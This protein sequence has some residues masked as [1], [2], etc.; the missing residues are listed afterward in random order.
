ML[1]AI[2]FTVDL[3]TKPPVPGI[4][5][6]PARVLDSTLGHEA[7]D[8]AVKRQTVVEAVVHQLHKIGNGVRG[9]GIEQLELDQACV[10]VHQGLG[11]G[12]ASKLS[13]GWIHR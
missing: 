2:D 1:L 13:V 8:H 3:I 12:G 6:A 4:P 10:G 9:V 7:W 5:L 11:H